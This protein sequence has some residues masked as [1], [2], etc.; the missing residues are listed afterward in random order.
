MSLTKDDLATLKRRFEAHEHEFLNN[1]AYITEAAITDR[2]EEVDAEWTLAILSKDKRQTYGRDVSIIITVRLTICGVSKDGVG[3]ARV[4]GKT[5]EWKDKNKKNKVKPDDWIEYNE[6]D[7]TEVNEAEKSAA[8]DAL[9]RA[10]RLFGIGRYL[11]TLPDNVRD[12]A[13]MARW[14]I[15]E[16]AYQNGATSPNSRNK[17]QSGATTSNGAQNGSQAEIWPTEETV[18]ILLER[19]RKPGGLAPNANLTDIARWASVEDALDVKEWAKYPS[20]G[21]A[22]HAIKAAYE[23]EV[24]AKLSAASP[25][26]VSDVPF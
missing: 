10:A 20:A 7:H 21:V 15:D 23:A 16:N 2:I 12:S 5:G 9:K 26:V 22:G 1:N 24:L 25:E 14:L 3:M 11:L 6:A 18:G 8:T 13:S 4:I 19:I 17:P